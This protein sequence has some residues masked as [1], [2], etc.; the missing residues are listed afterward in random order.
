MLQENKTHISADTIRPF[1]PDQ[2]GLAETV[3]WG[4]GLLRRQFLV[5]LFGILLM[6]ATGLLYLSFATPIYTAQTSIYIEPRGN[7]T[8]AQETIFGNDPIEIDSQIQIIKSKAIAASVIKK[9]QLAADRRIGSDAGLIGKLRKFLLNVETAAVPTDAGGPS[10]AAIDQFEE[11]LTVERTEGVGRVITISYSATTAERAAE[12]AN[13][14]A[15]AYIN[16]QLEAKYDANR[17]ATNWLQ[18][19]LRQL[20]EQAD[21]AQA[22]VGAFKKQNNIVTTD[23]KT[24]DDQ[25]VTDLN[26][27]LIAARAQTSD[28]LGRLNRLQAALK[29]DPSDKDVDAAISEVT[30]PAVTTLRQQYMEL[31]RREGEWSARFG[32]DHL[33]VVNLRNR[34]QEIRQ[35]IFDELRLSTDRAKNDY[36]AAKQR[37]SVLENQLAS[38]AKEPQALTQAKTTLR[39]LESTATGY[40]N[41]YNNFLQRYMGSTQQAAFPIAEARVISPALPPLKRSKPKVGLVLA[42]SLFA[43]I[44]LGIG[45]SVL[46]DAMDRVFRTAKQLEEELQVPCVALVPLIKNRQSKRVDQNSAAN[47]QKAAVNDS[48]VFWTVTNSPLSA[49]AEAIRSIKLTIDL[50]MASQSC[51]VI[52]FTSTVP[53]EGKSTLAGALGQL[54]GQAQGQV[55][56]I[57]CDLRNPSL[58]RTLAPSASIGL[59]DVVAGRSSVENAILRRPEL[60]LALLPAGK[61]IPRFLTSEILGGESM[62]KLFDVLRQRYN[63]IIVDLPPLAPIIDVRASTH[64]IDHYV[65]AVEWGRTRID[66]I[67]QTLKGAP[68]IY[69]RLVGTILNKA[70]MDFISRYDSSGMYN[71]NQDYARYGYHA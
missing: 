3:E 41:L 67:E 56:L 60:N 45:L 39:G 24:L 26:S 48:D 33:A 2:A 43:G 52:G 55:L 13:A 25:Q 64:L 20:G 4:V 31:A 46:R 7:P 62:G 68:N 22:A 35:S 38:I 6:T 27:R 37:Q 61:K 5:I 66:F 40:R 21:T 18:E 28:A 59:V 69:E 14:T 44:G 53:G 42:L 65:L 23:G 16:D 50:E 47:D 32:R 36:E 51:K 9:L 10:S 34:M 54:I 58:S 1:V 11:N 12:I 15:I 57:D 17:L 30:N 49:F 29:L 71:Y 70:D 63:Y 19:R 8:N